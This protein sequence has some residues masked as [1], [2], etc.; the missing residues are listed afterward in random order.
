MGVNIIHICRPL[1]RATR[2]SAGWPG[3]VAAAQ[4]SVETIT[5]PPPAR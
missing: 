2:F 5:Q 3:I 4:G 1:I